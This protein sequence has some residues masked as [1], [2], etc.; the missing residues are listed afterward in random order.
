MSNADHVMGDHGAI[1]ALLKAR[2]HGAV[3]VRGIRYQ[4]IYSVLAA[5]QNYAAGTGTT[6][7]E[8]EGIEDIDNS[9]QGMHI[10]KEYIQV[11]TADAPWNWAKLKKPLK[12]FLE[13]LRADPESQL[14]LVV[15][16]ELTSDI[17]RLADYRTSHQKQRL[18]I[19]KKFRKL[20]REVGA[21]DVEA[22]SLINRIAINS[23]SEQDLWSELRR[24]LVHNW[25]LGSDA[26]ELYISCLISKFLGWAKDRRTVT[27][28]DIDGVRS[29]VGEALSR[30]D[31]FQ[32]YGRGLLDRVSWAPDKSDIDFLEGKG[33]RPGHISAGK[34]V[35]RSRWLKQI[36]Q[37]VHSSGVCIVR[38]SSGQGKSAL[39]YRYAYEQWPHEHT[40]LLRIAQTSEHA[41]TV[42][43]YLEF[44]AKVGMP[45]FL[46]IDDVGYRTSMWADIA[47]LCAAVGIPVLATARHEDWLRFA[48]RTLT[49]F[50]V[51]DPSLDLQEARELFE[52]LRSSGR[53]HPSVD[54]PDWAYERVGTP[55]LLLEYLYLLTYGQ[56]LEERL[57][58]QV[59]QFSRLKEDPVKIEIIRRVALAD[60]LGVPVNTH[61]L[62]QGLPLSSDAQNTLLSLSGEYLILD[63]QVSR[64]LH[65]V[66]SK[67]L[68]TILHEGYPNIA[69]TALALL[70]AIPVQSLAHFI[71]NVFA[72]RDIDEA[73]LL[74][75]IGAR[76]TNEPITFLLACL[77]GL[78]QAGEQR[79]FDANKGLLDE[80]Y[81]M[82]GTSGTFLV[83][84]AL[85]PVAKTNVVN[86]IA[87]IV[88]PKFE[89]F[90][91]VAQLSERAVD[92]P[93]GLDLCKEFL[94][95]IA[96]DLT[97][98][99]RRTRFGHIGQLL[100]WCF[101]AKIHLPDWSNIRE[102][103]MGDTGILELSLDD[104]CW[105]ALGVYRYD[106]NAYMK[107][108]SD[109]R[110]DVLGY[111]M[112]HTDTLAIEV[113]EDIV[114]IKFLA[115][116]SSGETENDQVM[117]RLDALRSALPF[118]KSYEAQGEWIL[119]S[120]LRPSHDGTTKQISKERLLIRSDVEKN[121]VWR[122]TV[123]SP[124]LPD[125]YYR[126]QESWFQLRHDALH[127]VDVLNQGLSAITIGRKFDFHD[128][129]DHGE[130]LV[131][132]ADR[133]KQ[134]P[135]PPAQTPKDRH[136]TI[137]KSTQGWTNHL[138]TFLQQF[139]T[140][141]GERS[142]QR[143][144]DLAISSF[145]D[146]AV[147]L[148][149]V[150][151]AF[152]LISQNAPDYFDALSLVDR[153]QSAYAK[154]GEL[155]EIWI[156]DPPKTSYQDVWQYARFRRERER[157]R[158]LT[159]A[160][161]IVSPLATHG[162]D[163]IMPSDVHF[164]HP[165]RHLSLAFTVQNPCHVEREL[166]LLINALGAVEQ[167]ADFFWLI[168]MFEGRRAVAGCY[169]FSARQ[170]TAL[171]HGEQVEWETFVPR[172][173]PAELKHHL[174]NV[175]NQLL[176]ELDLRS[177]ILMVI[178]TLESHDR[179]RAAITHLRTENPFE[180][181]LLEQHKTRL[182]HA[183]QMLF[184]SAR[185]ALEQLN[186]RAITVG[187]DTAF[188]NVIEFLGSLASRRVS[189]L[190]EPSSGIDIEELPAIQEAVDE[191]LCPTSR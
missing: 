84:S 159:L 179:W 119:P 187:K 30:E 160:A 34:D 61:D 4:L 166:E 48:Q 137:M 162:V 94:E 170:L 35:I 120:G 37:A 11:K 26:V 121:V 32:A 44:R 78:F 174:P 112:L 67:H 89:T 58:D 92:V 40:F 157:N 52:L 69:D 93:R 74:T 88:G 124:Y 50:E 176:N 15:N 183:E 82:I 21:S 185:D 129:L 14:R 161:Q 22:D 163:V 132:L 71:A 87:S 147:Q 135:D 17:A 182:N 8:L 165:L 99:T 91:G 115:D 145:R 6:L 158:R 103:V 19:Q 54:S 5:L 85:M 43:N 77:N 70:P 73:S 126:Y 152:D 164:Q 138:R 90:N 45:T 49:K 167:S 51:L 62:V 122:R 36:D 156:L 55:Q 125:S 80:A 29:E 110:A 31:Q 188:R 114:S 9:L 64:G 113:E 102:A 141:V 16:F 173:A 171:K 133:L 140:Y 168:P 57:R 59:E 81:G 101:L 1:D 143:M 13:V 172:E 76:S 169:S 63:G 149:S 190:R 3:N 65:W 136:E 107:W 56:M 20:C 25:E 83:S 46:L 189:P 33:T 38:S 116:G 130:L 95:G 134:C 75:G 24:L 180:A 108:F 66:R 144:G 42:R 39:L 104:F 109:N 191:L 7:V 146:A 53:I 41:E 142:N 23:L 72:R 86:E 111:L 123:E 97:I 106:E 98:R 27:R 100:D 2:F 155:L 148:P 47:Q 186:A 128:A 127:F 184:D 177:K 154:L 12:S 175:S 151:A 68:V 105:L 118:C 150:H 131:K 153:E 79:Y 96:E 28:L 178:L 60:V 139:I 181:Q 10:G 18:V 117:R